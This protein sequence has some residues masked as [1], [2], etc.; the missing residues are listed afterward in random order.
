VDY[1]ETKRDQMTFVH[2][3]QPQEKGL[4][5]VDENL[6]ALVLSILSNCCHHLTLLQRGVVGAAELADAVAAAMWLPYLAEDQ[7]LA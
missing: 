5:V 6:E 3:P 4:L 1:Q 2:F 7:N